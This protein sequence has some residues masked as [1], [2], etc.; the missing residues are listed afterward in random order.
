MYSAQ[1]L[2]RF[3]PNNVFNRLMYYNWQQSDWPN[4]KYSIHEVEDV[5]YTFANSLGRVSGILD[6]L[7]EEQRMQADID[8]MVA[9]AV[10]TSAIEG[11]FLSRQ[12]VLS[13]IRN[14]LGLNKLPEKIKDKRAEGIARLMVTVRESY[15][16]PLNAGM[17]FGWHRMIME[18]NERVNKGQWRVHQ[19][20]MQVISGP[21]GGEVVHFEA[22]PSVRVPGEMEKFVN[23]FNR[24]APG[25]SHQLF[26]G[27]VRSAI[28]HLYFESIHP[29]EDG[30]GRIGRAISE[31]VL[32]QGI[33]RPILLSLSRAVE[34][35][36]KDYYDALKQA[37]QSNE[38]T[39]WIYYFL[40]TILEAQK[41]TEDQVEFTLNKA[42]FFDRFQEKLNA[43]Q[44]K[45]LRRMLDEGPA[46]FEG[47]M[48]ARKYVSLTRVSKAT[49]TRDLQRLLELGVFRVVG[50]GRSTR[51]EI[52]LKKDKR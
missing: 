37:Q 25:Q 44:E 28:A 9:E 7:P 2:I 21:I 8:M 47:G 38:I 15:A 49:A 31:K 32:S 14:N 46:G 24:T 6:S 17:L 41:Q 35:K 26:H 27:P 30:N 13:S 5:L 16:K 29:F 34:A 22:P 3:E 43:R 51:Y 1:I 10:K 39:S 50:G 45:V 48:N 18:G 42:R 23:W 12:D 52:V 20:P 40:N 33:G 36:R 19:A 4:F 11:E